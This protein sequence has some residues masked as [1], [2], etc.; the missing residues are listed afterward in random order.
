MTVM[1][2]TLWPA[3]P[4]PLSATQR[5]LSSMLILMPYGPSP[6]LTSATTLSTWPGAVALWILTTLLSPEFV[7]QAHLPSREK[8]VQRGYA[9][10]GRDCTIF[11]VCMSILAK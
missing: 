1:D 4:S 3:T 11:Q 8:T 6:V 10:I 2:I 7:V 9:P 5:S